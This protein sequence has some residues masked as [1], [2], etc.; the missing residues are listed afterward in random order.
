MTQV[1][2]PADVLTGVVPFPAEAAAAYRAAG[3]WTGEPLGTILDRW[4]ATD[5]DRVAVVAGPQRITYGQLD[6]RATEFAAGLQT[7]GLRAGDRAVVQLPNLPDLLVTLIAMF[8][9]GVLPVLALP[10][11]RRNEIGYLCAHSQARAYVV[12]DAAPRFDYR[13]L[14]AQVRAEHPTIEHVIVAGDPGG[15]R[16][17]DEVVALGAGRQVV[18][19][20]QPVPVA[21]FLLSGGTTGLPKLIPRTHDDYRYQLRETAAAMGF[22]QSGVYLA[23]LPAAHNAALGC[24]GVL[25]ALLAGGRVVLAASP[26]PD[27]VGPLIAAERVTLTTL[28]PSF[29]TLWADLADLFDTDLSGLT[30]EVGGARLSPEDA[31][32]AERA[33]GATVSRWFGMAEGVLSF[34]RA[35]DPDDVRLGTEGRPMSPADEMMIV[36][37]DTDQPLPSGETGALLVRGP[38]TLRGYYD[39]ADY[40]ARSFTTDGFLRT[41]DLARFTPAGHL[42]IAGRIK[43]IVNRAGEKVPVEEV[44]GFLVRHP[45]VADVAVVA[46]PDHALGERTCAV[47]V[48]RGPAPTLPD[49]R[50]FLAAHDLADYK[51]PDQIV[52][53]DALPRTSLGKPDKVTLTTQLATS[54]R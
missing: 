53:V 39:A 25:G 7:L 38:C 12:V 5:P 42:V 33:L 10:A 8:R 26:S 49:L 24:P 17:I 40:N 30:I 44:E 54:P 48:P 23:A 15:F 14:A 1:G 11:H 52:I 45:A 50:T 4:V 36:S 2:E 47:V 31:L 46:L 22:D 3:Y 51:F 6:R 35:D 20:E 13:E 16:S 28:M 37:V 21:F 27:E 19:P 41:G 18:P 32:S 43:D 29:L 9:V 34:T